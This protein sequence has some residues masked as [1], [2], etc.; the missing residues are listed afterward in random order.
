MRSLVNINDLPV[1][2]KV[3]KNAQVKI[4]ELTG[5]D[6]SLHLV[7]SGK[8]TGIEPLEL[9]VLKEV[10]QLNTNLPWEMV[11]YKSREEKFVTARTYAAWLFV[12]V[13]RRKISDLCR[14]FNCNH[15]SIISYINNVKISKDKSGELWL[16]V[17]GV[18]NEFEKQ[19]SE[20]QKVKQ[21]AAH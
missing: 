16:K 2:T 17:A 11:C 21:H 3:I 8:G 15:A 5:V 12:K 7:Y 9:T 10:I 14:E 4:Y 19:Y 1:V 20:R 13:L 6:V 18:V